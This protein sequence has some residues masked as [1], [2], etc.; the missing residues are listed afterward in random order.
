[1]VGARRTMQDQIPNIEVD[2]S[3]GRQAPE[4]IRLLHERRQAGTLG[5]IVVIHLGSN[6]IFGGDQ[7]DQMMALLADVPKVIFVNV[8]VPRR[9]QD[10]IN[11][12]LVERA[13]RY[14][15]VVV[16]DWYAASIDC[17]DCF[18]DDGVHLRPNGAA[19]YTAFIAASLEL[20]LQDGVYDPLR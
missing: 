3:I 10:P 7:F 4:M 17:T 9:W 20:P 13:K 15:N 6:G 1:M 8:Q 11:D 12:M 5:D 14:D 16:A 19:L 2:A 18:I